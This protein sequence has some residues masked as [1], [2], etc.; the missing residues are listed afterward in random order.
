MASSPT[1]LGTN[2][3]VNNA[4]GEIFQVTLT[5]KSAFN[6]KQLLASSHAGG[7]KWLQEL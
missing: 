7:S 4:E 5:G 6:L 2:R 1:L 3:L